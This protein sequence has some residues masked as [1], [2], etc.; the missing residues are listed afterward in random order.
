[1]ESGT[2]HIVHVDHQHHT[3][4]NFL[5]VSSKVIVEI[6]MQNLI[7][8][9][10]SQSSSYS[11]T[12]GGDRLVNAAVTYKTLSMVWFALLWYEGYLNKLLSRKGVVD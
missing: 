5:T 8:Y 7:R 4:T 2:V 1:M 3:C 12:T 11:S 6:I 9:N 10:S